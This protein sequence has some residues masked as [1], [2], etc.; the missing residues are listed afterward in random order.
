MK[1]I[2]YKTAHIFIIIIGIIFV[3]LSIFHTNLWFDESYSVGISKHTFID[4]WNIG[5]HDVHPVLYYWILHIIGLI[6]NNSILVYRLFSG[7]IIA[8]TGIL[9]Y[10][11][12]RKD[13]GEKVGLL[14]SFL[15]Y[16]SP[17]TALFA[18]EIRMYALAMLFITILGIYAYRLSK[19]QKKS[20]WIIFFI[21]SLAS[22]Y[23]H[24]YS[25]MAAGIINL[26][27]LFY[28]IK[29]K[30]KKAYITQIILGIIQAVLYLPWLIY[31]TSQLTTMHNNGFWISIKFPD[32][33]IEILGYQFAGNLNMTIGLVI[34]VL[35]YAY[36]IYL[37]IKTKPKNNIP[38]I[39]ALSVYLLVIIAAGVMSMVLGTH[40]LYY[41]YLFVVTGLGFFAISF[42][43]SNGK[44]VI[45]VILCSIILITGIFNQ[46]S[47]IKENYDSSNHEA[48]DFIEE[49][50]EAGDVFIVSDLGAGTAISVN[51]FEYKH[52]FYNKS[53]W[54][55]GEAY[56][57]FGSDFETVINTD[58]IE[59]CK[60]RTWIIV[61]VDSKFYENYF[62]NENYELLAHETFETKYRDYVFN[63]YLVDYI[64]E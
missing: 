44:T 61:D 51:F 6:T 42:L 20:Y 17:V 53:D 28:F 2:N 9:G 46:V 52:Y 22:I 48:I 34:G 16:F 50:I 38:A 60:T 54:G 11:H 30:N 7:L 3:N 36:C 24:Y 32:T 37:I 31:F 10:T 35:I 13:F 41:R 58:F 25:L 27:L 47:M 14:F 62:D 8:I 5:G 12:I 43:F 1:K 39:L 49:N 18:N 21:S 15:I 29:K 56:K 64:G 4:I 40:I 45:N 57:A 23:T 33:L 19:K 59:E 26:I 55:V 63:L